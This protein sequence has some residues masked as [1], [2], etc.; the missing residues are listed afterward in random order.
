MFFIHRSGVS[1]A[2]F[3]IFLRVFGVSPL[4]NFNQRKKQKKKNFLSLPLLRFIV[5]VVEKKE[6]SLSVAFGGKFSLFISERLFQITERI[7]SISRKKTKRLFRARARRHKKKKRDM[8]KNVDTKHERENE[9]DV[10]FSSSLGG[11]GLGG[12]SMMMKK[13]K[14]RYDATTKTT[15]KMMRNAPFSTLPYYKHLPPLHDQDEWEKEWEQLRAAIQCVF[16]NATKHLSF[17]ELSNVVYR[18]VLSGSST[19]RFMREKLKEELRKRAWMIKEE[20]K[21]MERTTF[22]SGG[23]GDYGGGYEEEE[24]EKSALAF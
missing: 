21:R 10:P 14:H 11:G 6:K 17:E 5:V 8:R 7:E 2:Y 20:L 15:T 24:E 22:S 12:G 23:G 16:E 9:R 4:K 13:Q 3:C 18:M 1:R 19:T